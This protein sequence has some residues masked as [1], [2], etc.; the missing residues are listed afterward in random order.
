MVSKGAA[1]RS[2]RG[3]DTP[4][5]RDRKALAGTLRR[6]YDYDRFWVVF[7]LT[8]QDGTPVLPADAEA[9]ELVVRIHDREGRAK[10][11]IPSSL[12]RRTV[13]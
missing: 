4:K 1:G 8:H 2:V 3:V 11:P 12:T 13:R 9:V 5:L 7:P 6:N 10:W